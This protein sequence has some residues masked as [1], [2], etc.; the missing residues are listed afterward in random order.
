M[1]ISSLVLGTLT[2]VSC[3]FSV[4]AIPTSAFAASLVDVDLELSLLQDVSGSIDSNEFKLLKTGY[5]NAFS[6]PDLF[7]NFISKGKYGKIA[8][9]YIYWSGGS[10]QQET[11]GWTLIDSVAAS[12][13]FANLI[14]TASR[15]FSGLT[16]PGSAINFATPKFFNNAFEGTRQ[17]IDISGDGAQNNGADTA[18][19]RDAA[20][21][22]GVDTINGIVILGESG[23]ETFYK[24]KVIGGTNASGN[25]AFLATATGFD[26]FSQAIT[27]KLKEEIAPTPVPEPTS[28]IGILGL[29]AFG[30]TT[31][32]KRKAT[33]KA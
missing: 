33:V 14:N 1:K 12:Q 23:L 20:L 21:A 11:V 18:A 27:Q 32:R 29:G 19:A 10:S 25:P 13:N 6:N 4:A 7:N 17:V 26:T 8:V 15:P 31:L 9:N 24:N 3:G 28:I 2:A 30:V 5:V 16:A 22:A